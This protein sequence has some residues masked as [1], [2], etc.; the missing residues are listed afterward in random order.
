M[1]D[2][3]CFYLANERQRFDEDSVSFCQER[4]GSV[5]KVDT[6]EKNSA[7]LKY[8]EGKFFSSIFRLGI[9]KLK[10]TYKALIIILSKCMWNLCMSSHRL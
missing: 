7:L 5:I 8:I 4:N 1:D 9:G 6:A 2:K 10:I 3:Y